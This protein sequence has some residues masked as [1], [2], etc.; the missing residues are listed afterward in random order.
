MGVQSL[1]KVVVRA[2]WLIVNEQT[3]RK[4]FFVAACCS[5]WCLIAIALEG[6][7]IRQAPVPA[8]HP[9]PQTV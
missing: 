9:K 8:L 3:E 7:A 6:D 4:V 5:C 2:T 1:L